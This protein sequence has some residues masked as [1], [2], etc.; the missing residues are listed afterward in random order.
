MRTTVTDP[1][2]IRRLKRGEAPVETVALARY[3]LGKIVVRE[4]DG[5]IM[6]ARIVETE[7]YL[8][9][10]PACHAFRGPT[11]RNQS[12]FLDSGH[13]YVY[14][15][16]GISHML[17]IASEAAGVG[18][19]VL[20]RALEPLGG[21]EQMRA[22]HKRCHDRDVTRGPGRLATALS[23]DRRLDGL[24]AYAPGPLWIGSD[25]AAAPG[26]ASSVRIGISKAV[27][28]PL[29][30]YIAGS[31]HVSGPAHLRR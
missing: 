18:A 10:D 29:R 28:A 11:P 20:L 2:P 22:A 21:M 16:Y 26:I 7:A 15:C 14:L 4:S 1:A 25:A 24:D 13:I 31:R 3:L 9:L 30:F 6:T 23:V 19:G 17:N 27:H 12:L 8:P 5:R